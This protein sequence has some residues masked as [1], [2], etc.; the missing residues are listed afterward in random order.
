MGIRSRNRIDVLFAL[1]QRNHTNTDIFNGPITGSL[2]AATDWNHYHKPTAISFY[3]NN[4]NNEHVI[5]EISTK[6]V[7]IIH[8]GGISYSIL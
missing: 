3:D 5:N 6:P 1:F 7:K 8:Y 2:T 4:E